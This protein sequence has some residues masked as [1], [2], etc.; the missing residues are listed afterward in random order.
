MT[1]WWTTR[2]MGWRHPLSCQLGALVHCSSGRR[3]QWLRRQLA[4]LPAPHRLRL[5]SCGRRHAAL[6]RGAVPFQVCFQ[7]GD[8]ASNRCFDGFADVADTQV[9]LWS[10]QFV[11]ATT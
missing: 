3:W 9:A 11:L 8:N 7:A 2:W 10:L 6:D 5:Q 4:T 1:C